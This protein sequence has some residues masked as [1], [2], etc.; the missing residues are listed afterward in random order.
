MVLEKNST[1]EAIVTLSGMQVIAANKVVKEK[2]T[3]IGFQNV[4]VVGGGKERKARGLWGGDTQQ[5]DIP[6]QITNIRKL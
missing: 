1:Y 5:I 6:G 2:F 3:S 4:V